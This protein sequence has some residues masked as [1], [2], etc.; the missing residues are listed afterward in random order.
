[1][2]RELPPDINHA[3]PK[4]SLISM[5]LL[6]FVTLL[7]PSILING[8]GMCE[9]LFAVKHSKTGFRENVVISISRLISLKPSQNQTGC[10]IQ[11]P[12]DK[13]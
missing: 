10:H 5:K 7:I 12:A 8:K 2:Y 13:S 11:I 6:A 3:V 9:T 4:W 1:M